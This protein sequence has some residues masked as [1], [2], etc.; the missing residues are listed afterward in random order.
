MLVPNKGKKP[1]KKDPNSQEQKTPFLLPK[2]QIEIKMGKTVELE[3]Y[4][5]PS[6]ETEC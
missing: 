5:F 6:K 4:A 3:I 1:T 2:N